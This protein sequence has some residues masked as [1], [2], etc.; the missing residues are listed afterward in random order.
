[1]LKV[2]I[3][4][5]FDG[6][7]FDD[8]ADQTPA[9]YSN[10]YVGN[11]SPYTTQDDL[12]YLFDVGPFPPLRTSVPPSICAPFSRPFYFDCLVAVSSPITS[13]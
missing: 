2:V 12:M 11:L 9:S 6:S 13:S 1:L 10:V 5:C 7:R 4:V 3:R 8:V